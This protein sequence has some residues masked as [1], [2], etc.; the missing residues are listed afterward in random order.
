MVKLS[1]SASWQSR[2]GF[3][4]KFALELGLPVGVLLTALLTVI[5][6]I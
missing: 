4:S 5:K 1:V 6:L 3:S 2:R